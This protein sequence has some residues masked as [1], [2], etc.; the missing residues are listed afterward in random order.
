MAWISLIFPV[1]MAFNPLF[2][3]AGDAL[4]IAMINASSFGVFSLS[5]A[6]LH[7]RYASTLDDLRV[8]DVLTI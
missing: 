8:N 5:M 7:C 2:L 6:V 1:I 3:D 4:F